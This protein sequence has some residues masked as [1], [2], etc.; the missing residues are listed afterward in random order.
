MRIVFD[1]NVL[2]SVA[3]FHGVTNEVVEEILRRQ[4]QPLLCETILEEFRRHATGKFKAPA[5]LAEEFLAPLLAASELI[6]PANIDPAACRDPNDLMI[7]GTAVAGRAEVI[8]TGDKDLLTLH[9]FERISILTPRQ[10]HDRFL[11]T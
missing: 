10:F 8:L 5:L 11:Q 2:L 4:W 1:T 3:F 6:S 7:L 9:P